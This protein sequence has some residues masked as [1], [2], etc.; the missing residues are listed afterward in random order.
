MK[1][2]LIGITLSITLA[3]CSG[4]APTPLPPCQYDEGPVPFAS[5]SGAGTKIVVIGDSLMH[6]FNLSLYFPTYQ[7]LNVALSG[8][9]TT[10]VNARFD[11][12]V[13]SNSPDIII[14]DGGINDILKGQPSTSYLKESILKA[15][16]AGIRIIVVGTY[17][18]G[19]E[20]AHLTNA[21]QIW[22]ADMVSFASTH[23]I[24]YID[25][26]YYGATLGLVADGIHLNS[27]GYMNLTN[28]ILSMVIN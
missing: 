9:C 2:L 13:L 5:W 23:D 28:R 10:Q 22:N 11:R 1:N 3:S 4:G 14:M 7:T 8:Q 24:E 6:M 18:P 19:P 17:S 25:N 20:V 21:V 26:T 12:D 27:Y 16:T 15:K